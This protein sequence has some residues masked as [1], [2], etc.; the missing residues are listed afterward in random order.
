LA[1]E[2]KMEEFWERG[3]KKRKWDAPQMMTKVLN[4]IRVKK[5]SEADP[6]AWVKSPSA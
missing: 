5:P 6:S 1:D 2:E 4:V 3:G